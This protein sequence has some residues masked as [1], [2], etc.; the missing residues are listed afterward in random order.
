MGGGNFIISKA[1]TRV[2]PCP[3]WEHFTAGEEAFLNH[4]V[5]MPH[6]PLL[7]TLYTPLVSLLNFLHKIKL[8]LVNVFPYQCK[9]TEQNH[10]YH[11]CF[12]ILVLNEPV[13]LHPQVSPTLPEGGVLVPHHAGEVKVASDRTTISWVFLH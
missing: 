10:S 9:W 1:G 3:L 2:A 13:G 11:S 6:V 12:K 8:L 5:H 4:Q 7:C